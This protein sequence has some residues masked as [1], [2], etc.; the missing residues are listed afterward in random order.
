[1]LFL[2]KRTLEGSLALIFLCEDTRSRQHGTWKRTFGRSQ[3]CWNPDFERPAFRTVRNQFLLFIRHPVKVLCY[4]SL[5]K[6]SQL[7]SPCFQLLCVPHTNS[8]LSRYIQRVLSN[9]RHNYCLTQCQ[10]IFIHLFRLLFYVLK[11]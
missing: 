7:R 10:A 4:S 1:M 11:F 8:T 2:I 3:Q 6:T 5:N 9:C